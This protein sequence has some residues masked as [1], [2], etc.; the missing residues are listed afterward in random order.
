M[1]P[2]RAPYPGG[3]KTPV[4]PDEPDVPDADDALQGLAVYGWRRE[5]RVRRVVW[6]FWYRLP[7][8][9]RVHSAKTANIIF[10]GFE[11]TELVGIGVP[12]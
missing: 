9:R 10:V 5:R 11:I 1:T 2:Q 6:G 8:I 7:K 3:I 12:R 4:T